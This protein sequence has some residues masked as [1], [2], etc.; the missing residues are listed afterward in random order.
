MKEQT[1]ATTRGTRCFYLEAFVSFVFELVVLIMRRNEIDLAYRMFPWIAGEV[2]S[3]MLRAFLS[4]G[5]PSKE[6]GLPNCESNFCPVLL[7]FCPIREALVRPPSE[8]TCESKYSSPLV[9]SGKTRQSLGS[10]AR[11]SHKVPRLLKENI[12][13]ASINQSHCASSR[14]FSV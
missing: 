12:S 14:L 6:K 11:K 2:K 10:R 7:G 5:P 3:A 1:Y 9:C 4:R 8:S 13:R